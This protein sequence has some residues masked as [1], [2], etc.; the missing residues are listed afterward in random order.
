[1]SEYNDFFIIP[2]FTDSINLRDEIHNLEKLQERNP[3]K[4]IIDKILEGNHQLLRDYR[5]LMETGTQNPEI[6]AQ[7]KTLLRN[8][9]AEL[10]GRIVETT[11][12]DKR[13]AVY[14]VLPAEHPLFSVK[15]RSLDSDVTYV[16][17]LQG[18]VSKYF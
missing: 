7:F 13:Y 6:E 15:S 9:R 4:P 3:I 11:Y 14:D 10:N 12:F 8:L 16:T 2:S 18:K 17:L 5:K 1:M